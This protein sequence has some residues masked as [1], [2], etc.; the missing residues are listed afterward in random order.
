MIK[1]LLY[2]TGIMLSITTL[3]MAFLPINKL[4][5]IP[6]MIAIILG[7]V[8]II[9]NK[10]ENKTTKKQSY[11]VIGLAILGIATASIMDIYNEKNTITK[12]DNFKQKEEN[13]KREAV[14]ELESIIDHLEE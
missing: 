14:E 7:V 11:I 6:G 5:I 9:K 4:A 13:S 12:D 10:K 8:Y 2:F 1:S 3:V